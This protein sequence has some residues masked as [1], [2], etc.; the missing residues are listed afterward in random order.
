MRKNYFFALFASLMLFLAIPATAQNFSIA[1]LF[2][3]WQFTAEIEYTD[4]ATQEQK[5]QLSGDCAVTISKDGTYMAKIIGFAG[6]GVQQNINDIVVVDGQGALKITNPNTPTL[7]EKMS[8]ANK[9]GEYPYNHFVPNGQLNDKGEEDG[10]WVLYCDVLYKVDVENGV[11][12]VPDFTVVTCNHSNSTA[13]IVA[14][15][16]NVKMTRTKAET[17]VVEDISG[18]YVFK[19]N[20]GYNTETEIP[21][22][23]AVNIVKKSDDNK[24]YEAT[25]II[26]GYDEVVMP[27]SYDGLLLKLAYDNTYIYVDANDAKNSVRFADINVP[28]EKAGNIEFKN[29]GTGFSLYSGFSFVTDYVEKNDN[30]EDVAKATAVQWY[31]AGSLKFPS[32][33]P[34]IAWEGVYNVKVVNDDDLLV[35]PEITS[36]VE[37]PKEFKMIVK[38]YDFGYYVTKFLNLDVYAINYGGLIFTPSEDGKSVEIGTGY[39]K[40]IVKGESYL[41]LCNESM[42][43]NPIAMTV[44]EDGTMKMSFSTA[45]NGTTPEA[46]YLNAVVEKAVVEDLVVEEI[47]YDNKFFSNFA[48][49]F[50]EAVNVT[51]PA[52]S[53][54]VKK[55]GE[56]VATVINAFADRNGNVVYFIFDNEI[57]TPGTYTVDVPAGVA[58][59]DWDDASEAISYTFTIVGPDPIVNIYPY[60][61]NTVQCI[62]KINISFQ[63]VNNVE[64]DETKVV[65]LTY[66]IQDYTAKMVVNEGKEGDTTIDL[67]FEEDGEPIIFEEEGDYTVTIPAGL[68]KYTNYAGVEGEWNEETVLTY[69]VVKFVVQPLEIVSVTPTAGTVDKIETIIVE[70]NQPVRCAYNEETCQSES[71]VIYLKDD[72]GN[73]I[74]L[75]KCDNNWNLPYNCFEYACG[76]FGEDGWTLVVEPITAL[77]TYSLDVSQILVDYG[78]DDNWNFYGKY[79][80][81]QGVYEW[82]I[83]E[84]E[85]A[86]D[87]VEAEAEAAAIYDI[88]GRRVEKITAAGIYIINGKKVLVK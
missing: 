67:S 4:A 85:N 46:F 19:A 76:N 6:S 59:T 51:L 61:E 50:S 79:G 20:T 37:Y 3:E 31:S 52:G 86:I 78:R 55:D 28:A 42:T 34:E 14:K 82:T 49:T 36:G 60:A 18:E 45:V 70:F 1:D 58:T 65:T 72:K 7:W 26:E 16:I 68:F 47:S 2:G 29:E 69:K 83:A 27:A 81:C 56:D 38:A 39:L 10:D 75:K 40:S 48:V 63:Y 17:V 21:A 41:K 30:G 53:F 15:F 64:V 23:F 32:S 80:S 54:N 35:Q 84:S 33:A 77:G 8:L 9:D 22:E 62:D 12:S 11:I 71:M 5:D 24:T 44:N 57:T 88:T 43:T 13:V 73:D 66:G 25:L 87:D 74:E